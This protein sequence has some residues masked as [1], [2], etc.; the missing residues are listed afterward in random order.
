[1]S[2]NL[3]DTQTPYSSGWRAGRNDRNEPSFI[4]NLLKRPLLL[5]LILFTGASAAVLLFFVGGWIFSET[6]QASN[7]PS[8]KR[9][10]VSVHKKMEEPSPALQLKDLNID[11]NK[12]SSRFSIETSGETLLVE[13]SLDRDLQ[14]YISDL[15]QSS[16]TLKAAAVVLRPDDGRILAMVSY[17]QGGNVGDLCLQ[18]DFPAA[19]LFKI[20]AAAAAVEFAGFTPEKN[21]YFNGGKHTLYKK[22]LRRKIGRYTNKTTFKKAFGLSINPVFGKLGIYWLGQRG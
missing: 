12:I 1:M 22:Q 15:L 6:S 5:L 9:A 10:P 4:K 16:G 18:A 8:S 11:I 17:D 20:V 2:K 3:M 13:S 21:V 19:S 7:D 14:E